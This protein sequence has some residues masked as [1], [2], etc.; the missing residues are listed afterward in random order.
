MTTRHSGIVRF[1]APLQ[2]EHK[3]RH[4]GRRCKPHS[5]VTTHATKQRGRQSHKGHRACNSGTMETS[6][7][8]AAAI[9][10]RLTTRHR[11]PGHRPLAMPA[12]SGRAATQNQ[13]SHRKNAVNGTMR[14]IVTW[15]TILHSITAAAPGEP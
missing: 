11:T 5:P 15:R 7:T 6:S 3:K 4:D 10:T 8:I 12:A 13:H 1:R 14:T 9:T 2:G